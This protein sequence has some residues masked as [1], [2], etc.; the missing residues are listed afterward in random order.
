M[1][2]KTAALP[3][4]L[5]VG[6]LSASASAQA[7]RDQPPPSGQ[8]AAA[9]TLKERLSDKASDE[10]RV[11]NCKVPKDRRGPKPRPGCPQG[12]ASRTSPPR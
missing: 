10:Q 2:G 9:E 5:A 3:I 4:V 7:P 6:L 12:E 11:N 8:Q 1:S